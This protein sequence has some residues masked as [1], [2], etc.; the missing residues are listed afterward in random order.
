VIVV[1]KEEVKYM[2]E[3]GGGGSPQNKPLLKNS[4][5]NMKLLIAPQG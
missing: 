2:H 5:A 1:E 3:R 4:T